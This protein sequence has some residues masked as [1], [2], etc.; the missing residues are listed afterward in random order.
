M[1]GILSF[2]DYSSN[3]F[4]SFLLRTRPKNR[5][6]ARNQKNSALSLVNKSSVIGAIFR[7]IF[8]GNKVKTMLTQSPTCNVLNINICHQCRIPCIFAK[9]KKLL[10]FVL[11]NRRY[12]NRTYIVKTPICRNACLVPSRLNVSRYGVVENNAYAIYV[13]TARRVTFFLPMLIP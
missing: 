7:L 1:G 8:S 10:I 4:R 12:E 2:T 3:I 6:G 13:L 5:I 11:L 9:W